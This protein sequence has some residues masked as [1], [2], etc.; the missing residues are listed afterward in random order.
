MNTA[1]YQADGMTSSPSGF[2]NIA[3]MTLSSRYN[4]PKSVRV[5][6]PDV[7]EMLQDGVAGGKQGEQQQKRGGGEVRIVGVD[8]EEGEGELVRESKMEVDPV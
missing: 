5:E 4:T 6:L 8:D 7:E 1:V 3:S 2:P